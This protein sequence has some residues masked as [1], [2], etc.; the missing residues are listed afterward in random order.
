M[1]QWR[2][3]CI[4][5]FENDERATNFV[6]FVEG[7]GRATDEGHSVTLS[8]TTPHYDETRLMLEQIGFRSMTTPPTMTTTD[9]SS[10]TYTLPAEE[11]TEYVAIKRRAREAWHE[12]RQARLA[13]RLD[14]ALTQFDPLVLTDEQRMALV[15]EFAL[16]H[17]T[18]VGSIPFIRGLVGLLRFQ[19]RKNRLAEWQVSEYA[20]TQ[21]GE[22]AML[23]YIRLLRGVLGMHLVYRD[24]AENG[25]TIDMTTEPHVT[26]RMN[27]A[28]SDQQL[29]DMLKTLPR[30]TSVQTYQFSDIPRERSTSISVFHPRSLFQWVGFLIRRC[31][32]F[33][34]SPQT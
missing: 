5:A 3:L 11:W 12:E 34:H 19:L 6:L 29:S 15:R 7:C 16:Q 31:L 17:A 28:L 23:A 26:W 10:S 2:G 4:A 14:E 30:S 22:D 33:L 13:R 20:L 8:L 21:N 18:D 27:H 25:I 1:D 9:N 24:Q 32:S